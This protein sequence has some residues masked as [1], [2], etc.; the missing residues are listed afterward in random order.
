MAKNY[1]YYK[2]ESSFGT[3]YIQTS[4]NKCVIIKRPVNGDLSIEKHDTSFKKQ[5][6]DII[7]DINRAIFF[8]QLTWATQQF[9]TNV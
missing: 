9:L 4:N 6:E 3:A 7:T 8:Q 1:R 5:P 2:C